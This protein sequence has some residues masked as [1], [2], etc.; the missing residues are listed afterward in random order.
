MDFFHKTGE[1]S[2]LKMNNQENCE[3]NSVRKKNM[4]EKLCVILVIT[5]VSSWSYVN[6]Q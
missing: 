5:K 3:K 1:M 2:V 4:R 6:Y